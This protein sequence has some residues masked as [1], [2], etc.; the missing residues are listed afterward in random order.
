M[1]IT[2]IV[3]ATDQHTSLRIAKEGHNM[4]EMARAN[5]TTIVTTGFGMLGKDAADF[6]DKRGNKFVIDRTL[7][8]TVIL[9]KRIK[10]HNG[11]DGLE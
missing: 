6:R 11:I 3:F 7:N 10:M 4:I 9:H 2:I 8:D 1:L 5:K